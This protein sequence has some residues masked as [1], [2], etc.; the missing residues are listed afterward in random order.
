MSTAQSP[1]AIQAAAQAHLAM[2]AGSPQNGGPAVPPMLMRP[3]DVPVT[4]G[5]SILQTPVA[6][7]AALPPPAPPGAPL[8]D[9]DKYNAVEDAKEGTLRNLAQAE[10][11]ATI[12]GGG[13]GGQPQVTLPDGTAENADVLA[14]EA[15][16]ARNAERGA[17][18]QVTRD[19]QRAVD[20]GVDATAGEAKARQPADDLLAKRMEEGYD[21]VRAVE[22]DV[23]RQ[24]QEA[25]DNYKSVNDEM[26]KLAV[27]QPTDL[28]GQAG[29]NKTLG[30]IAI[31]LGGA[32]TNGN[33]PNAAM[34]QLT[35]MADRTVAA[36]KTKFEMLSRVGQGDQ[37]LFG[38]LQQRLQNSAAAENT[39]K[40]M[41]IESQKSMVQK[42]VNQY[43]APKARANGSKLVADMESQQL[44]LMQRSNNAYL[45]H[46]GQAVQLA[47]QHQGAKVAGD[48]AFLAQAQKHQAGSLEGFVGWVPTTAEHTRLTKIVGGARNMVM[49]V[50][51]MEALSHV[52]GGLDL[53]SAA[54]R[55]FLV[56][57]AAQFLSARQLL[58]TGT[59]LEEGELKMISQ[60][61]PDMTE[62]G[63]ANML[64][65]DPAAFYSKMQQIRTIVTG[66]AARQVATAAPRTTAFDSKDPLWGQYNPRTYRDPLIG[67]GEKHNPTN[68][69][70][71]ELSNAPAAPAGYGAY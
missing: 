2:A 55:K 31:F 16:K 63:I 61:V 9:A 38:M 22:S 39:L 44:Q 14:S 57:A 33:G 32:G 45:T 69:L 5:S 70:N 23:A 50:N 35:A 65:K 11:N 68:P 1:Q 8:S 42:A 53:K 40:S 7:Q 64:Q 51:N 20:Q 4:V 67:N 29:V 27:S 18:A 52:Q 6:P 25:M 37:T 60:F 59:R 47:A 24:S 10:D 62:A 48:A 28:F 34:A 54:G 21:H 58:E 13:V 43:S 46:A 30:S 71:T 56:D 41:A 17:S 66:I 12:Y 3:A 49:V 19:T 15:L 26:H 36:Q